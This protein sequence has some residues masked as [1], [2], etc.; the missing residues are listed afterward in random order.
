MS[1][2]SLFENHTS[3]RLSSYVVWLFR[4]VN[5]V[6]ISFFVHQINGIFLVCHFVEAF[7][8]PTTCS[9]TRNQVHSQERQRATSEE[10]AETICIG[11]LKVSVE[12]STANNNRYG[13]ENK[14]NR[15]D[16]GRV[17][18]LQSA[19]HVADLHKSRNNENENEE[20]GDGECQ[21]SPESVRQQ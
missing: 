16:L 18:T 9:S 11:R 8:A 13:E 5:L 3:R 2:H 15:N 20:V 17:E 19:I 12:Y 6:L 10:F 21:G 1:F 14:L 7:L 4:M